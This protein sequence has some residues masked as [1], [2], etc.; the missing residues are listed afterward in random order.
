MTNYV[1]IKLQF[2]LEL[3]MLLNRLLYLYI[4]II[5]R[6]ILSETII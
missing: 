6:E 2:L 3:V 5:I 1:N 4:T